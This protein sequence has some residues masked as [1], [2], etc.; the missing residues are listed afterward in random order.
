MSCQLMKAPNL[1]LCSHHGLQS[2]SLPVHHH[3]SSTSS[4]SIGSR[5]QHPTCGARRR[6]PLWKP[7]RSYATVVDHDR[8]E[9]G[10]LRWPKP[11]RPG[12]IPTPY[13]IFNQPM[14][15]PY[16]KAT[17]YKLVKIYHPDRIG[18]HDQSSEV[19]QLPAHVR[20]ERY[21][22]VIAAN[23]ILSDP[24]KRRAYDRYGMG[25]AGSSA[26]RGPRAHGARRYGAYD[27]D[28]PMGNATWEDW[29]RWYRRRSSSG[30]DGQQQQPAPP[31]D[32]N[33]T[34]VSI[35]VA[36]AMIGAVLETN[37]AR[38]FSMSLTEQRERLHDEITRDIHRRRE[39]WAPGSG[40]GDKDERIQH[41]IRMRDPARYPVS[42]PTVDPR[43]RKLLTSRPK[44]TRSVED[45][46]DRSM[47]GSTT[48]GAGEDGASGHDHADDGR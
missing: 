15:A 24:T 3:I 45:I 32:G 20:L 9:A 30:G 38:S 2:I 19:A 7:T 36:F 29:E 28:S 10:P 18:Q 14:D 5:R 13:Q 37:R 40:G 27:A 23:E 48:T 44:K 17:F 34:F 16:S 31:F 1:L 25:W 8:G 35:I 33:R 41:F 4:F 22:L 39:E 21:R 46:K 6:G 12:A 47:G 11:D 43:Y 26:G 42:D